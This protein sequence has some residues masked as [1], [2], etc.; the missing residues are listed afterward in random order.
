MATRVS[1]VLMR[2]GSR[3]CGTDDLLAETTRGLAGGE[4]NGKVCWYG[5]V[6]IF[7]AG[8]SVIKRLMSNMADGEGMEKIESKHCHFRTCLW[9]YFY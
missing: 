6:G 4:E 9:K 1:K 7:V 3:T 2:R 8:E 5:I